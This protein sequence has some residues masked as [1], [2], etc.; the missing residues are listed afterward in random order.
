MKTAVHDR[1]VFVA[2]DLMVAMSARKPGR[3]GL[4][5]R[6]ADERHFRREPRAEVVANQDADQHGYDV[7]AF[8]DNDLIRSVK[9]GGSTQQQR[10]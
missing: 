5:T 2:T 4:A 3:Y 8:H 10:K 9:S 1:P 7:K 6:F